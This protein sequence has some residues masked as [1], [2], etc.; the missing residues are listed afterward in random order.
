[1][2]IILALILILIYTTELYSQNLLEV[3]LDN[4]SVIVYDQPAKPILRLPLLYEKKLFIGESKS[5]SLNIRELMSKIDTL[6]IDYENWT[7]QDIGNKIL[8]SKNKKIDLKQEILKVSDKTKEEQKKLKKEIRGFNNNQGG[9]KNY[10]LYVSKPIFTND[11]K[12]ALI[13]IIRGNSS[14]ST[15]LYKFDDGKWSHYKYL[16]KWYY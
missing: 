6:K 10:P 7:K 9:W 2:K 1:M 5:D 11:K 16:S 14:G 15:V 4:E 12:L 8:V 13:T 3:A